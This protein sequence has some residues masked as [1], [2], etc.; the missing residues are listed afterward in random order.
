MIEKLEEC[1]KCNHVLSQK[2]Y[3]LQYCYWCDWRN[4]ERVKGEIFI[5]CYKEESHM[6][7]SIFDI[8]KASDVLFFIEEQ[9]GKTYLLG[10]KEFHE[11]LEANRFPP[12]TRVARI[13]LSEKLEVIMKSDLKKI[14][15]DGPSKEN[16][17]EIKD[18]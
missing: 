13:Q 3:D 4:V 7:S 18:L 16:S 5:L 9:A 10:N 6:A 12:G 15:G 1:P 17:S 14:N 11:H 2:E 8:H